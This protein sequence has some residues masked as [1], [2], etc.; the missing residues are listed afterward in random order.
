MI[1][2]TR[3]KVPRVEETSKDETGIKVIKKK[4]Q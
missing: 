1:E 4:D 2:E 3:K